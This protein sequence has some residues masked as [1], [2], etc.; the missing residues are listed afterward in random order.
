VIVGGL[1]VYLFVV[2]LDKADKVGSSIGGVAAVVAL[3]GPYL[4]PRSRGEDPVSDEARAGE[5]V[6]EDSGDARAIGGGEANTGAEVVEDDAGTVRVTRSGTA[7]A[8]GPGSMANTGV[9]R[10]PRS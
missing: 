7:V 5:V 4:L 8:D 1:T 6:V 2:G 9:R 3:V 10:V